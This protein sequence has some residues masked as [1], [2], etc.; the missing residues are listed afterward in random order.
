MRRLVVLSLVALAL[1]TTVA[2]VAAIHDTGHSFTVR[3][4]EDGDATVVVED[5][6]DLSNDT[7]RR[8]YEALVG[9]E[10][11]RQAH[12]ERVATRLDRGASLAAEATGRE[13]QAGEV[14]LNAT[15]TNGTGVV[16]ARGSWSNLA[17]VNAKFNILELRQPF[18]AGFEVNRTLVVAAPSDYVRAAARPG[19]AR[20][21]KSSAYWADDADLS[22]FFVRFE[23][24][25]TATVAPEDGDE[26][27]PTATVAPITG[28]GLSA[29]ST[30]AAVALVPALL[31]V[32]GTR[33]S[34]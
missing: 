16:R 19:P 8:Q 30:A 17:A 24:P 2:P 25:T 18:A 7:E 3:L 11:R 21:L 33:G 27:T 28:A 1:A 15:E 26:G 31:F 23:G 20:A 13:V 34:R 14:T 6:Y 32:L 22:N 12:R 9:N 4:A 10:S 5:R 29:F